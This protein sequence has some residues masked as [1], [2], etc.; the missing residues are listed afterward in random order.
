MSEFRSRAIG[1]SLTVMSAVVVFLTAEPSKA[2]EAPRKIPG[3]ASAYVPT[4]DWSGF[5]LGGHMG[6]GRGHV[7]STMFDTDAAPFAGS[8]GSLF[9]GLQGGY[10]FVFPSRVFVGIEG[11]MS[12]ANFY[13]DSQIASRFTSHSNVT[14]DIDYIGRA[15]GRVGYAFDRWLIYGTGGFTWSQSRV[16]ESSRRCAR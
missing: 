1:A 8:F 10:N 6:Y 12:F 7:T 5:Y 4:Y 9:V 3:P 2:V 11:D 16:L 15:R 13:A 14:D